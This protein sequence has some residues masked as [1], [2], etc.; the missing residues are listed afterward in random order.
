MNR[1]YWVT[2]L[3]ILFVTTLCLFMWQWT[4]P[5][6]L[7]ANFTTQQEESDYVVLDNYTTLMWE[8]K[9]D[10]NKTTEYTWE[11]ALTY[12]E[13]T[14]DGYAGYDDWRLP[15]IKELASIVDLETVS[16]AIDTAYFP[17]TQSG[18]YWSSTTY[19]GSTSYVWYVSFY[20][21][22]DLT[23]YKTSTHYVRC[24]R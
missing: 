18:H 20:D 12:C 3:G 22:S 21:G 17:N 19:L 6:H 13:A 14:M 5:V 1:K 11:Q 10:G 7:Q 24:T 8:V 23:N 16:P 4:T 2:I 9:T 15:N